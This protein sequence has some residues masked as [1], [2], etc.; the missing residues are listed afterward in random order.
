MVDQHS[1]FIFQSGAIVFVVIPLS[2]RIEPKLSG[3]I[4]HTINRKDN[5]LFIFKIM[6]KILMV[7]L[8]T[9]FPLRAPMGERATLDRMNLKIFLFLSLGM[10]RLR[11]DL[12]LTERWKLPDLLPVLLPDLLANG[13]LVMVVVVVVALTCALRTST[14]S[15]RIVAAVVA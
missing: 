13:S 1:I 5:D 15:L 7:V 12:P 4:I 8:K 9:T 10:H 3:R 2:T 11:M 6:I 14:K